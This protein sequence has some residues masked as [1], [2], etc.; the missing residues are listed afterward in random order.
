[1]II[2]SK[3]GDIEVVG[4]IKEFKTSIDPKNLEFI[5]TLLSSNLYSNPEQSFIRE[6]VSN[7]WD[8]HVEAGTTDVPIIVRFNNTCNEKSITIRDYGVGLSPERFQEVYCNIGSSTKRE[9]NDFTGGFGIGKYSS[10]ACSNTVYITSY[11]K[12]KA[13]YYVM[14]KSGNSITTNLLD[15]RATTDKDGVE[16]TIKNISSLTPFDEAL[17]CIMFFPNVYISGADSADKLNGVKIKR[18]K[19]FAAASIPTKH[20]FLLG[21]VLYPCD[22]DC[23]SSDVQLFLHRLTYTGIVVKFDIGELNITPNRESII[24]S[25]DTIK[26]IEDRVREAK[27]ELEALISTKLTKD[28]NN[29]EEYFKVVS[30]N[31]YYDP[32]TNELNSV[33]GYKVGLISM[34]SIPITYRGVD[35][36]KDIP[37]IELILNMGVPNFR[38]VIHSNK[39]YTKVPWRVQKNYRI[40]SKKIIVLNKNVRLTEPVKLYLK[41]YYENYSIMEDLSGFEFKEWLKKGVASVSFLKETDNLDF[42]I[43]GIYEALMS[44]ATKIDLKNDKKYLDFKKTQTASKTSET[45]KKEREILLYVWDRYTK[46]KMIFR[47]LSHAIRYIRGLKRGVILTNMSANEDLFSEIAIL[48]NYVFIKTR[49]DNVTDIKSSNMSCLVD[50][51]WIINKDP[52]LSIVATL[53]KHFP[54]GIPVSEVKEV[55]FNLPYDLVKEFNRLIKIS[56]TYGERYEYGKLV[57]R[58][59]PPVDSYTEYLCLRLKH[60]LAKHKEAKSLVELNGS[61]GSI[62]TTAVIIKTKAYR[63]SNVAYNRVKNNKLIKVLC[64]K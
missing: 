27:K 9:S 44:K 51:D 48:K 55:N 24:Y 37:W 20:R 33:Y 58:A 13:Y 6:I 53:K 41:N 42:I 23:L 61:V 22:K 39:I 43:E 50:T 5:T 4:D 21:N 8:S 29:I 47:G 3:Q 17:R 10:L 35:L 54:H 16:V 60:Y 59:N 36:R 30:D 49:N 56:D 19:N 26:K 57:G 7:A 45:K 31:I 34:G 38:G 28:Y 63:V 46:N 1:M 15:E 14:V 11:Y 12:G 18:F 25:S 40:S 52:M 64:E 62:I 32:V 2:D